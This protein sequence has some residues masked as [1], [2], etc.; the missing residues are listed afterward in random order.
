MIFDGHEH[1]SMK[2]P[3]ISLTVKYRGILPGGEVEVWE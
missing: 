2:T 1:L 3:K